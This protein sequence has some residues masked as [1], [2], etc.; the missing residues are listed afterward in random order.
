MIAALRCL[1]RHAIADGL[2]HEADNPAVR[3][4]KPRRLASTRR[5]LPDAHVA[6]ITRVAATTGNDPQLDSLVL[7]LHIETACRRGGALALRLCD[8]DVEQCLIRLREKGD[9]TRWQPVS[10][11]LIRHLLH[12]AQQRGA[13]EP[14]DQVLRYRTGQPNAHRRYDGL[15]HGSVSTFHGWRHSRSARTGCATQPSPGL[16]GSVATPWPGP[17][18]AMTAPASTYVRADIEEI[19][20][21]LAGLTGEPHPLA[22]ASRA[23]RFRG[24]IDEVR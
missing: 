22:R 11:T 6:E 5:A 21:A 1:Y 12:H 23:A 14:A 16:N 7:R 13:A 15:W 24:S 17:T 4:A 9:T 2:I 3:V 8:L 18:R 10:P 19:A 20:L